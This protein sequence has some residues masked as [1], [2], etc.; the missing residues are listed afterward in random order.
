MLFVMEETTY[1]YECLVDKPWKHKQDS[2]WIIIIRKI[3]KICILKFRI[4]IEFKS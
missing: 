3:K 4:M 1:C 2:N